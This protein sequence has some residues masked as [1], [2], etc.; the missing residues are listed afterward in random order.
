MGLYDSTPRTATPSSTAVRV[1]ALYRG[2]HVAINVTA[3]G[4]MPTPSVT[5]AIWGFTPTAVDLSGNPSAGT[6][7]LLLEGA[8]ITETGTTVLK[9]YPGIAPL[10]NAAASDFLPFLWK[11]TMDHANAGTITYSVFALLEG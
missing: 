3:V 5:P 4:S 6:E 10:A 9:V 1:N 7:Y 8:A 2:L 11:V